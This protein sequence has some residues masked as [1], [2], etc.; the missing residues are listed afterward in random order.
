MNNYSYNDNGYFVAVRPA[1]LDPRATE[2]A[3]SPVYLLPRN[4]THLPIPGLELEEG[5]TWRFN[6]AEETWELA[7]IP[8]PEVIGPEEEIIDE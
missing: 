1:R 5:M 7:S 8:E 4:A 6:L 3:G 2:R